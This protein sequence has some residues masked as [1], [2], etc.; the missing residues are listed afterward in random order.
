M[1]NAPT[2]PTPD[3]AQATAW[4][5]AA[6]DAVR[7]TVMRHLT[8]HGIA[9][10]AG[11][12][13]SSEAQLSLI[14]K[15]VGEHH[16]VLL[17]SLRKAFHVASATL[18]PSG[19]SYMGRKLIGEENTFLR[20]H[21]GAAILS[22]DSTLG[23][24][25]IAL[26][27]Y[28]ATHEDATQF[29]RQIF[30]SQTVNASAGPVNGHFQITLP[31]YD[32]KRDVDRVRKPVGYRAMPTRHSDER[33]VMEEEFRVLLGQEAPP[34]EREM[35]A[36][37]QDVG[38]KKALEELTRDYR[39]MFADSLRDGVYVFP[40][41]T[42]DAL[43]ARTAR[44]LIASKVL[45]P[46]QAA[47]T[48]SGETQELHIT[49][50]GIGV[51]QDAM[52]QGIAHAGS[53]IPPIMSQEANGLRR[54]YFNA[55]EVDAAQRDLLKYELTHMSKEQRQ[56]VSSLLEGKDAASLVGTQGDQLPEQRAALRTVARAVEKVQ[57]QQD[58]LAAKDT[59]QYDQQALRRAIAYAQAVLKE[60]RL[61]QHLDNAQMAS[62]H[63]TIREDHSEALS[64]LDQILAGEPLSQSGLTSLIH[65]PRFADAIRDSGHFLSIVS[66][67][68]EAL[69]AKN[70]KKDSYDTGAGDYARAFH[71]SDAAMVPHSGEAKSAS[72]H[73]RSMVGDIG[74]GEFIGSNLFMGLRPIF[75]S[76]E[77][78]V[79]KPLLCGATI[80]G[81]AAY[82]SMVPKQYSIPRIL[83]NL[84][85][86]IIEGLG[87]PHGDNKA[88]KKLEKLAQDAI[89]EVKRQGGDQSFSKGLSIGRKAGFG[90]AIAIGSGA[91]VAFNLVEDVIVHLPLALV[92]VGVGA[93]GGATGRKVLS[94]VFNDVGDIAGRFAPES[95]RETWRAD[96]KSL[97]GI[98]EQP[99][100]SRITQGARHFAHDIDD[101]GIIVTGRHALSGAVNG[102]SGLLGS[103]MGQHHTVAAPSV[104][105]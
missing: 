61:W 26:P 81:I 101:M 21:I 95:V 38:M 24:A 96:M 97:R 43:I 44:A 37:V 90:Q 64:Q 46:A 59:P 41:R 31:V 13:L 93:A 85:H 2:S 69:G 72:Y 42:Q 83:N 18:P 52:F 20:D 63:N 86:Q 36:L 58:A 79:K 57:S 103:V 39:L 78:A 99:W 34:R 75:S 22:L 14:A 15:A 47:I 1:S 56:Q 77:L 80:V 16:G 65:M 100:L 23:Y 94:P 66:K 55:L 54:A 70:G 92:S 35:E 10:A 88:S 9:P 3:Y 17:P 49:P 27:S 91:F 76:V 40:V 71:L 102:V 48:G 62:R 32:L 7:E 45:T 19:L 105:R 11:T 67:H 28:L 82:S 60:D 50:N 12:G 4:L 89:E 6:P 8:H 104:S 30:S 33:L 29:A 73:L 53:P 51:L 68:S 87:V 5:E 98:A 84:M 25:T 74:V